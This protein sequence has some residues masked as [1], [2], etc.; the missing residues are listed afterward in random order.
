MKKVE[1]RLTILVVHGTLVRSERLVTVWVGQSMKQNQFKQEV[2]KLTQI[3]I[4]LT[5]VFD[6]DELL[7]M[8]LHEA[9]QFTSADAG[10]LYLRENDHLDFAISQND[11]LVQRLG[12]EGERAEKR[13]ARRKRKKKVPPSR[14]P[15]D[16]GPK[17]GSIDII[18]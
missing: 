18:V 16:G 6:L 11:T 9:R 3:G 4:A 12:E 7:E 5:S 14:P 15:E 8:I 17:D 10:S 13:E 2:E 1:L